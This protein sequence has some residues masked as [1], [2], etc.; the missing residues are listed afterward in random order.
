MEILEA[1]RAGREDRQ[2][3]VPEPRR[4]VQGSFDPGEERRVAGEGE[5]L[6]RAGRADTRAKLKQGSGEPL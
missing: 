1:G 4:Q 6:G 5:A 3:E 2:V